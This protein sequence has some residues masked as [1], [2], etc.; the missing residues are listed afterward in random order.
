MLTV[1]CSSFR[2]LL[3]KMSAGLSKPDVPKLSSTVCGIFKEGKP[4]KI[5][6]FLQGLLLDERDAILHGCILEFDLGPPG[7]PTLLFTPLSHAAYF[8]HKD[9]VRLLVEDYSVDVDFAFNITAL[10]AA[11]G[12]G[13]L[14]IVK[15]LVT[16]GCDVNII[17]LGGFT[18]ISVSCNYGQ[19]EV[20]QHLHK[21]GAPI[22]I[23]DEHGVTCL[24]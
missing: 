20:A 15:C 14:D 7:L 6:S 5:K 13:H 9:V 1:F 2:S 8:G 23:L 18:A 4:E 24:I 3:L 17:T 12:R 19:L 10:A 21:N 11:A 22:D 16:Q